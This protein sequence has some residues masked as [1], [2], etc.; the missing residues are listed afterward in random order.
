MWVCPLPIPALPPAVW[1]Q[2]TQAGTE[3]NIE[4]THRPTTLPLPLSVQGVRRNIRGRSHLDFRVGTSLTS[5]KQRGCQGGA[6]NGDWWE[7]HTIPSNHF[8]TVKWIL[9]VSEFLLSGF[10][11]TTGLP[12]YRWRWGGCYFWQAQKLGQPAACLNLKFPEPNGEKSKVVKRAFLDLLA[13][14]FLT[15]PKE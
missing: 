7:T 1:L 6:N 11:T 5:Q 10:P 3:Y 2:P 8:L 15:F 9:H 4:A 14:C 12:T 13:G